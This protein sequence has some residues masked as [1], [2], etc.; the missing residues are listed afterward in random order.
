M[1]VVTG[2]EAAF[3]AG[4]WVEPVGRQVTAP[5]VYAPLAVLLLD[6]R[7]AAALSPAEAQ[8]HLPRAGGSREN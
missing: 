1:A 4:L 3:G 6:R 2:L 7:A 5:N 8:I